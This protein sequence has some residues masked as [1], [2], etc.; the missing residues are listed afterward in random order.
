[1]RTFSETL[2]ILREKRN[3]TQRELAEEL[4]ISKS[5][6]SMYESAK[7][8]PDFET[9]ELIADYF[10]V[11][12]NYLLGSK[13]TTTQLMYASAGLDYLMLPRYAD[14]ICCG[15]GGF[16]EDNIL[17]YVPIPSQGLNPRKEHFCLHA[18]GD[19]MTGVG[20]DDGDLMCFEK[21]S[22]IDPG[23]IGCFCVGEN[24]AM[25]KKYT[26]HNGTII[27]MPSNPKYDPIVVDPMNEQFRCIGVLKKVIKDF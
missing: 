4:N 13:D 25:C 14:R 10:N 17:D 20:I 9:L 27:L 12:M 21:T 15:N 16:N 19:S 1:M 5:A 11:D 7:R 24:E 22:Q 23:R 18:K 2:K 6:V 8:E 26:V 3:L